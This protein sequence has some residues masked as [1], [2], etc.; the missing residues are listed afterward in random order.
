[1]NIFIRIPYD[2]TPHSGHHS[3]Q[4]FADIIPNQEPYTR[5]YRGRVC[6]SENRGRRGKGGKRAWRPLES[7]RQSGGQGRRR[8][9]GLLE[10]LLHRSRVSPVFSGRLLRTAILRE[11]RPL[12]G[13]LQGARGD[14]LGSRYL[15]GAFFKTSLGIPEFED[16]LDICP[17]SDPYF[18]QSSAKVF[19]HW[20]PH[21]G[22][23]SGSAGK[24]RKGGRAT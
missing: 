10:Q 8:P 19:P 23:C 18:A 11:L 2:I 22:G 13:T 9:Y 16:S 21:I 14:N 1:M 24:P 12:L 7:I 20:E 3:A 17:R 5:G 4:V 6:K 15:A